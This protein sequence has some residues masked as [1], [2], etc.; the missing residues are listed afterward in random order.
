MAD[1]YVTIPHILRWEGGFVNHKDDK[2][3]ATN[4]GIT[5][6]TWKSCGYDK[7]GDGDID[8][9]DL[10]IITV[11]DFEKVFRRFYWNRWKADEIKSQSVADILVDWV[12][13]SGANGI[14]I[15]QR[16]LGLNAD[17]VVGAKTIAAVN[18]ED[19]KA[20][21][22]KV[23][24]ARSDFFIGIVKRNP[25]QKVFLKGWQNRLNSITFKS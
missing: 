9:D 21:F 7:D 4:K 20:F 6:S 14:K 22:N 11:E 25:S 5:L 3:G 19:P 8:V 18:A 16:L 23:W 2:G 12:Y 17:G 1:I 24:K 13:N 15:P 10:K